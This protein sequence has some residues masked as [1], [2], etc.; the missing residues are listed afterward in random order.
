VQSGLTSVIVVNWNRKDLLR[1]CLES[2]ARQQNAGLEIILVDNGSTDGSASMAAAEFPTVRLIANT[3]NRGFCGANNQGIAA[4]TGEFI[5]LLNND[6]EAEPVWITSLKKALMDYPA[7]GMA[8]SKILVYENPRCGSSRIDKVGHL[9]FPDGQNR[10]RGTG[11]MDDG[12][13]DRIEEVLW[14]DGCAAMYRKVM[15]DRIGGFD[16]DFFAYAD[17]AD[18]GLRAR[19][20]G[21]T[22]IYTPH[23]VVRHHRGATLGLRNAAR[24]KLIERNRVLLVIKSFPLGLLILNPF[25]YLARLVAGAAASFTE[26]GETVHFPGWRG[27]WQLAK[28]MIAADLEALALLPRMLR[29]RREI[30]RTRILS[31]REVRRLIFDY[32]IDLREL[33][34]QAANQ[35]ASH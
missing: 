33:A 15:L 26:E 27:K 22:C 13:F 4:A 30:D 1:K 2:L 16:E 10:G 31:P 28:A 32:R 5:A 7:A 19:I 9:I 34:T 21:W 18:L 3:E 20:A 24:V 17:D 11:A 23:A 35:A 12:Q 6:A 29:K 14:P 8:A 25:Y